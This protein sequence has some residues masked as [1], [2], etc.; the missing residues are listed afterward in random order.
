MLFLGLGLGARHRFL[1]FAPLTT[2]LGHAMI[3]Q[4]RAGWAGDVPALIFGNQPAAHRV[5]PKK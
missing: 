5:K 2:F 3:M 4:A 1:I